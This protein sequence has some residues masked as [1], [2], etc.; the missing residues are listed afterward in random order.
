MIQEVL[1]QSIKETALY[2]V[3]VELGAKLVPFGGFTMPVSYS[4]GIQ[5]EYFAVRKEAGIFDVK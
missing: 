5:A 3:H 2:N 4:E 1:D